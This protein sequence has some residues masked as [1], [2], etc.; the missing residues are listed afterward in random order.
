MLI[1]IIRQA[2]RDAF[3]GYIQRHKLSQRA[4]TRMEVTPSSTEVQS[5]SPKESTGGSIGEGVLR[6]NRANICIDFAYTIQLKLQPGRG[7][8][9]L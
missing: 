8:S 9:F 2:H 4:M 1:S 5:A 6:I 7:V 3:G